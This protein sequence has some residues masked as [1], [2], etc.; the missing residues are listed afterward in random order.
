M[1]SFGKPILFDTHQSGRIGSYDCHPGLDHRASMSF[2][3][4][5]CG[6]SA[7]EAVDKAFNEGTAIPAG[8]SDFDLSGILVLVQDRGI[9][10]SLDHFR[11]GHFRDRFDGI[12]DA[13][14]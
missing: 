14:R 2:I 7:D 4:D 12:W 5:V 3:L 6:A 11:G 1:R 10:D 13:H 8:I 9:K